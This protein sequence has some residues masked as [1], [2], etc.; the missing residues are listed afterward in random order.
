MQI[1]LCSIKKFLNSEDQVFWE[2]V[3]RASNKTTKK[4]TLQKKEIFN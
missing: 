3:P 1:S 4:K 2:E